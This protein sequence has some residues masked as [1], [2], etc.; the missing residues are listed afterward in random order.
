[1]V[2]TVMAWRVHHRFE[3]SGHPVHRLGMD[4]ELVE[5]VQ[6]AHEGD[7]IR[8][9]SDPHHR[10]AEQDQPR[11]R[12][13]PGLAKCGRQVVMLGGVVRHMLHPEPAHPVGKPVLPV[14]DEIIQHEGRQR[15]PPGERN[16][17]DPVR[18]GQH[19]HPQR[20]G[21]RGR[22]YHHIADPHRHRGEGIFRLVSSGRPAGLYR[23]P[24]EGDRHHKE[25]RRKRGDGG[26]L[27][28]IHDATR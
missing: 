13:E 11:E 7:H 9:K 20:D 14:I 19:H 22:V 24:F 28:N 6:P 5:Q 26:K 21:A 27:G 23:P 1:M 16:L 18:P 2:H 8:V 3:P 25:R 4:P 12:S 10:Q 15:A 17:A